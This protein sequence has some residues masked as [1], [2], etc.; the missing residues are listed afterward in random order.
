MKYLSIFEDSYECIEFLRKYDFLPQDFSED[1][2]LL[3]MFEGNPDVLYLEGSS[4]PVFFSE[5][6]PDYEWDGDQVVLTTASWGDEK[7][8]IKSFFE[9]TGEWL[10]KTCE[11]FEASARTRIKYRGGRG[12]FY[13]L[14]E[15]A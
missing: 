3:R 15:L 4:E 9:R 6:H 11:E 1:D 12:Y 8:A 10:R 13:S 2:D 7:D 5:F 14:F